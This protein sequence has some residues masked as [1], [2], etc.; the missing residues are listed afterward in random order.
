M[1]KLIKKIVEFVKRLFGNINPYL[2]E[3]VSVGAEV[4]EK[5]KNFDTTNPY[6]GDIITALIPGTVDD[7]VKVKLREYL[8][9]IAVQLR[10]VEAT[11]GLTDP[12][13]I[14]MAAVKVIQQMDKDYKSA[15]LHNFSIMVAKVA[16]DG[17]LDWSDAVYLLEW[18][19]QNKV[20]DA[21]E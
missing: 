4:A 15:F 6:I 3:A 18:Y 2:Q 8:P 20:K 13:Q 10:L 14:M 21:A 11:Q 5:V 1:N 19:Y 17:K 7:L 12:D 9:K 16:A